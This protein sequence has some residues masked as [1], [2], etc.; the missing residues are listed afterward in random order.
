MKKKLEK[1]P[2]ISKQIV[3]PSAMDKTVYK[4]ISESKK[5]DIE[6]IDDELD[7]DIYDVENIIEE[8]PKRRGRP[9]KNPK[10][11]E[12][13][14]QNIQEEKPKRRGRPKKTNTN[15]NDL[16]E[17]NEQIAILP[18]FEELESDDN[19][20]LS[21]L[22]DSITDDLNTTSDL[23]LSKYDDENS[24]D[25]NYYDEDDNEENDEEIKSNN[26]FDDENDN[27]EDEDDDDDFEPF[28]S[29]NREASI[30]N[31]EITA[32]E[33][34]DNYFEEGE[35]ESL[36][37]E[38]NKVVTFVGTS[39]NGTSFI[40]NNIAQFLSSK[41]VNTAIL[42]AT[43]NKSAYYIYT[44]DDD[45]LRN[46]A[47]NSFDNL[48]NGSAN[49]IKVNNNLS[50]FTGIPSRHNEINNSRPILETLIKNFSV[51]LIDGDFQTPVEYFDKSQ[52]IYLVQTMDVLTIQPLTEFLRKL[53]V[54]NVLDERKI[55]IVLNK[56]LRVRGISGKNIIGGMSNYNDPEMSFMTELFDR[57]TVKIAGQIPFDED[58]YARYLENIVE[59]SINVN[60]YPKEMKQRLNDLSDVVYPLL[61]NNK[62]K[63]K[64]NHKNNENNNSF[65]AGMN[66]T[67]D[68]M[69]KKY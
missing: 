16:V 51:V 62:N 54:K 43:Q 67:L 30:D 38:N 10:P 18:G 31:D 37:T 33:E 22:E 59:C 57:N 17:E 61:P 23:E 3:V 9:R 2:V 11:E 41:G 32:I 58:V 7:D 15:E 53:K 34:Y 66:N 29:K 19:N 25:E 55:R 49:G 36:L 69:R 65:S 26:Q 5:I 46:I 20:I 52:E 48:I 64:F 45:K 42:D 8:K 21:E 12:I 63:K 56:I 60:G 39:K 50:V 44:N 14:E 27:E 1:E 47:I 40:V 68:N 28:I 24:D 4:K 13:Q 35:F 6:D